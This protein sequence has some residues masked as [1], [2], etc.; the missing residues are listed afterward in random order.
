MVH[1][2]IVAA[3]LQTRAAIIASVL[4][5]HLAHLPVSANG[6]A[7]AQR[8]IRNV[9]VLAVEVAD[10]T[11][12]EAIQAA[13]EAARVPFLMRTSRELFASTGG[14]RAAVRCDID[15]KPVARIVMF[16]GRPM[17]DIKDVAALARY[18]QLSE[19]VVHVRVLP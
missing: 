12:A 9:P 10:E 5:V 19:A 2:T 16:E 15:G 8:T 14:E 11:Q 17:A 7:V 18:T 3:L 1:F 6:V 4:S 13:L